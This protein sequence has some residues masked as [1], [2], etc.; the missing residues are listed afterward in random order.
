MAGILFPAVGGLGILSNQ[1][2]DAVN[3]ISAQLSASKPPLVTRVLDKDGNQI[4]TLYDQYRLPA[5]RDQI[6]Q[7]MK[8]AMVAVEDKRFYEHGPVDMKGTMRAAI[9]DV[10]G[11][12]TQGAS[13]ITQQYVKNFLINVVHRD[14][15]VEQQRDQEASIARKLREARTSMQVSQRMSK[16][17]ILAGY[18]NTV[19]FGKNVYG[20]GAAAKVFFGTTPDK[21]TVAQSA[22]LAGMV[23]N[24]IVLSPWNN[25][26]KAL[27]RRNTVIDRMVSND[28]LS[29]Q[30]GETA[31]REPLGVQPERK[32]PSSSC[33]GAKE[34]AGFFCEYVQQYLEQH[35]FS[36]KQIGSGGYTIKTSLDPK[37]SKAA[38]KSIL[39]HVPADAD[40]VTNS[41]A[42]T[43]SGKDAHRVRAMVSNRTYGYDADEGGRGYNVVANPTVTFGGGSTFK[44]FTTAAA[45]ERG[46]AGLST[47]LPNPKSVSVKRKGAPKYEQPQHTSNLS[48]TGSSISLRT[49]LEKSPNTAFFLLANKVGIHN[50]LKMARRLGLRH[51]L[52]SNSVGSAPNHDPKDKRS[53]LAAYNQP[54]SKY[55]QTRLSFTLGVS[56]V[57][58]LEM[59]NVLATI[60]SNGKWCPPNPIE[61]ITD[62]DGKPVK[63]PSGSC[64][65]VI[66]PDVA[67]AL[68]DGMSNDTT[69]G[70]SAQAAHKANFSLRDF[71][72]TGTT[73]TNESVSFTAGIAHYGV[74]SMVYSDGS[75]PQPICGGS[76]VATSPGCGGEHGGAFG[77]SVAAP[78]YFE[79]FNHI[80]GGKKIR[81]PEQAPSNMDS[82]GQRGAVVPSVLG[83]H[84]DSARETLHKAGYKHVH[85]QHVKATSKKGTVIGQTPQGNVA[86]KQRI[87]L[88]VSTGKA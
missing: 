56:A 52:Q 11:G 61:S 7:N 68:Q 46:K 2:S 73:N 49:A 86:K 34:H 10:G 77:G 54:Q 27:D 80:L 15:K 78:P 12:S 38:R 83:A 13:S 60:R 3:E 81:P 20:V 24:P 36:Q 31:K 76:P 21:L 17:E 71:A 64:E 41:F 69:S 84:A 75:S 48:G 82:S 35:G 18:L 79:A 19:A 42:V 26:K 29:K 59:S 51:T 4:A 14:N 53:K 88:S 8:A 67:K 44:I 87:T 55:Y 23:N 40:K 45:L 28:A 22:L 70:T 30:H 50:V 39:K 25:P 62:R 57:S 32:V 47:V 66:S 43:G 16:D 63:V 72:K 9:N 65:Q 1:G 37:L 33:V 74:A 85:V 6:S 5:A 58:P